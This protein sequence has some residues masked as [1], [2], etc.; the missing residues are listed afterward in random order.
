MTTPNQ[1]RAVL[2]TI[3]S[4]A[5][6]KCENCNTTLRGNY[7]HHPKQVIVNLIR[8]PKVEGSQTL[9][10]ALLR[11]P[12]PAIRRGNRVKE[13][14]YLLAVLEGDAN[15]ALEH[16]IARGG[17]QHGFFH[18]QYRAYSDAASKLQATIESMEK[19]PND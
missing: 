12:R 17:D 5:A 7:K 6:A 10:P 14:K 1:T 9:L 16:E 4:G 18:G 13:L 3:V 11:Q 19:A 15:R 2:R 8:A